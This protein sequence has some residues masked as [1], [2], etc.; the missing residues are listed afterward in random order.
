[1]THY[2]HRNLRQP[3]PTA[4][5]V[6]VA[7]LL[8]LMAGCDAQKS[9][10]NHPSHHAVARDLQ[11]SP[12]AIDKFS[13]YA[14][15]LHIQGDEIV[16][17]VYQAYKG[18]PLRRWDARFKVI[19]TKS[20]SSGRLVANVAGGLSI[21]RQQTIGVHELEFDLIEGEARLR[22]PDNEVITVPNCDYQ[23]LRAACDSSGGATASLR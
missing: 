1:M 18:A 11:C 6:S 17:K 19:S 23:H 8:G 5:L 2:G 3:A 15:N 14:G 16:G 21:N 9:K 7:L 10:G 13:G 12:K 4:S 20:C 22:T